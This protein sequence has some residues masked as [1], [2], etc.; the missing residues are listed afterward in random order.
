MGTG[1]KSS[2]P[3][4][5]AFAG[6]ITDRRSSRHPS[7]CLALASVPYHG[8]RSHPPTAGRVIARRSIVARA[9]V[10]I[11]GNSRA[12]VHRN[13]ACSFHTKGQAPKFHQTFQFRLWHFLR[14]ICQSPHLRRARRKALDKGQ[15]YPP[16]S[17]QAKRHQ[18]CVKYNSSDT[19]PL[20][21]RTNVIECHP[22]A[23]VPLAKT[24]ISTYVPTSWRI[25][26]SQSTKG[27]SRW[28]GD[29]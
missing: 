28:P 29:L 23:F 17:R 4:A 5:A 13:A 25:G 1:R 6:P 18:R 12:S 27:V 24:V 14:L 20:D 21:D 22:R 10:P 11:P 9:P 2:L 26:E 7:Y 19:L 16:I 8:S 3:F 15:Y